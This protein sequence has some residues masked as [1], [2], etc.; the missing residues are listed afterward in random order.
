M[1]KILLILLI[2]SFKFISS[3]QKG[4][5]VTIKG[6]APSYVGQTIS[7]MEIEDYFSMNEA[8]LATTTVKEDSTFTLSFFTDETQKIIVHA[9]KNKSFLY[10][11]PNATYDLFIPDKDKYEPYRPGGNSVEVTFFNLDS[12]D[13]NY[14]ILQFQRWSD[15]FVSSYYHL[16]N[17][18][19]IEFA[20]KLD[21][22][23]EALEKTYNLSDSSQLEKGSADKYFKVFVRYSVASLDNIQFAA[24][25]NRYEKHDFYIINS[26]V[27]YKNDAYMTY[28]S[29]FYEKL[30]PRLSM[31]TNNRVYLGLL[32]SSPTLI[33]KALGTEYTLKKL[34]IREMIMVKA[35]AE[36]FYSKDFPQ[37]NILTVLDSV[38]NHSMFDANA[39]IA[40][41]L[42]NRLTQ[43]VPGGKAPD[44]VLKD[45]ANNV[46][47]LNNY[48]KKHLYL[49]FYDPV[50]QK[51]NIELEPLKKM[52][53]TYKDDINFV[54]IYP[55]D[56]YDTVT[57]NTY[58]KT[59][60]WE[61]CKTDRSNPIWKKYKIETFPSYVLID[62]YGYVVAAPALGPMPDGQYQ[63]IDR[64]FFYI[65]KVND[66]IQ[67]NER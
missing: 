15:E 44:F 40:R 12:T 3:A 24:E 42:I 23:K 64:T 14:K 58:L 57:L 49:H 29:A 43:I 52:Y 66:E 2:F 45:E 46:R 28:V 25:R 10:I 30:I 35:L 63:T 50:S 34:R 61:T 59:I 51:N 17:L 13:I 6:Y 48:G 62:G 54:T 19:P 37:T 33:M 26:P 18:K 47:T 21:D 9:N 1:N 4:Q 32:K 36:E 65:Q 20:T 7:F 60:P 38:A 56:I 53:E 67:K 39:I 8:T 55:D 5:I 16:K 27:E 22:F 31:E 11:Q 41:N